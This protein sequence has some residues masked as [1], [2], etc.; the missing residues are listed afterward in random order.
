MR[1]RSRV[2]NQGLCISHIGQVA[3][4]TEVIDDFAADLGV[5]FDTEG[6]DATV[7][8]GTEETL[9]ECVGGVGFEAG[10]FDPCDFGVFLEPSGMSLERRGGWV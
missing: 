10:V 3:C 9:G 6:E 4:K 8:I 5:A 1:S 2:N 7:G